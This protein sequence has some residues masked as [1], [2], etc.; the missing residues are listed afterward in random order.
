MRVKSTSS[1]AQR[2]RIVKAL[3]T[4][5]PAHVVLDNEQ[6]P[7][8]VTICTH[9]CGTEQHASGSPRLLCHVTVALEAARDCL[10]GQGQPAPSRGKGYTVTM[11]GGVALAVIDPRILTPEL[12]RKVWPALV[13]ELDASARRSADQ[14]MSRTHGSKKS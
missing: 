14:T 1:E 2:A 9:Q 3:T 8:A 10:R 6:W 12:L 5:T 7:Y 11:R 4:A 13:A